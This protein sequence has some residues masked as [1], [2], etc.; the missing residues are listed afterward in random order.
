MK[1]PVIAIGLDAADPALLESWMEQ[2]HLPTLRKLRQEGA[3]GRL[4]TFE[5]YRAE[6]PWTTFLTGCS[7]AKTGYW[8]PIKYRADTYGVEVVEAF[9]YET[10]PPFYALGEGRRV[11][12]FDMP[13][14]PLSED[15]D[16]IQVLAW[17][18]HSP[19]TPSISRPAGLLEELTERHGPHPLLRHDGANCFDLDDL[20]RLQKGL[21]T[22]IERRGAICRDLLQQEPWD[23]FLTVVGET[24][25][26]GHY[27]WHLS[28]PD[29]PLYP[30]MAD[31]YEGDPLLEVFEAIDASIGEMLSKAPADATRV[32]FSAHGMGANVM[33]LPSLVFLS[34]F[35]YRLS[36][37][38]RA[39]IAPGRADARLGA[40]LHGTRLAREGWARSV[41]SRT[42]EA[43][44]LKSRL[45]RELPHRIF[46][47]L[48]PYL[49]G[50]DPLDP[51]SPFAL[52]DRGESQPFQ[53]P[54]WFRKLWPQ[55]RAFAIPSFSEGYVRINLQGREP[56]GIV[57][58]ADYERTCDEISEK[59]RRMVDARTGMPMV[60]DLV[61]TRRS[62][63]DSDP[64]LPDA[65]IVVIWQEETVADTVDSPDV[66][67]IGPVPFLRTG[68]HRADGFVAA[69][70]PGLAA[71]GRLPVGHSLD[72]APTLLS[73][74]GAPIPERLEGK[75][76]L[77]PPSGS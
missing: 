11:A 25:V 4:R 33:D 70:G 52:R 5:H 34:E 44:A 65:D 71:G 37:P 51:D 47:R 45:K 62:A 35:L 29:H 60:K 50:P 30:L 16:G 54:V 24:H 66:G 48:E 73:L 10:H 55:M 74:M 75:P 57:A 1:R 12:V 6:T 53:P 17:G 64:R 46:R 20:R 72:L 43:N 8:S 27:F 31:G 41:W 56:H 2:G 63:K 67:R 77:S 3:Y 76:L 61:R 26:V 28:R 39:A 14:A 22:G 32:V 13:Q 40:P 49:G 21:L 18:A 69:A 42:R 7:P 36:F 38:G 23:L 15:V 59:L 58:P 68:S 19:Q 9:D